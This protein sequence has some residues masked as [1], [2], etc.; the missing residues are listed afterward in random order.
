VATLQTV[1]FFVGALIAVAL[2]IMGL[3][4]ATRGT[5]VEKIEVPGGRKDAPAVS[6][7]LFRHT[8]ELLTKAPL[9][10]GHRLDLMINGD[11]T[12]PRLW[13]DLRS[14][15][16]SIAVQMYYCK[17][18]RVADTMKEI[19]IERARAGLCVFALFD[20]FGSSLKRAY[21]DELRKAG[22]SVAKFRPLRWNSLRTVL[23]RS[24]ARVV[25]VDGRIGWTGGF[26]LDDKWLGNGRQKDQWRDTNV[27]FMGPAVLQLQAA[28]VACWAEATGALLTGDVCFPLPTTQADDGPVLAGLLHATP[29]VGSTPAERLFALSI[30]GATQRLYVT[31]SYF[32]PDDDFRRFLRQAAE[33][34]VDVRVLV[35]NKGSDV[36]S[37]WYAGRAIYEELMKC[38]IR[39]YEYQPVMLHAKAMVVDGLWS[40]VGSMNTD[41]RSMAFNDESNLLVLDPDV[42][43]RL[44]AI[45]HED[46]RFAEEIHLE[47]FRRRPWHQK[48]VEHG[49]HLMARIL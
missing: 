40:S 4:D 7:P 38:G 41:N 37:T 39:I 21:F 34:G 24:H 1:A 9:T 31:N 42:A 45:F 48:L 8:M 26:G 47:E 32:V 17:A 18:G 27:R 28:F 49:A 3:L 6:D 5:P 13:E 12:Y 11:E 44:E 2:F 23:H 29:E 10:H 19:L 36:K 14:A 16:Q 30:A 22:V 43:A 20:A 35:P 33:R 15:R 25:V 46:L